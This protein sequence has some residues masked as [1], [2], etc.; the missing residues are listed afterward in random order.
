ITVRPLPKII[1]VSRQDVCEDELV[2]VALNGL[3][4]DITGYNWNF[5]SDGISLE[6]GVVTTGG[7]FGVRYPNQGQY[8]ISVTAE[9]DRCRSK[10]IFQ[11]VFVHP[12][13][14][15]RISVASDQNP[16]DFCASDTL[17]LSVRQVPEGGT[18]TWTPA[19]YFQGKLDTLNHL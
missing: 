16:A 6:Y 13:P 2:N 17:H 3:E 12:R 18:Y 10:P 5:G 15:A 19:A 8:Q 14:D 7:P 4:P 1:F 9:K 11:Q